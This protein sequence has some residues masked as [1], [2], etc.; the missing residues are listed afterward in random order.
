MTFGIGNGLIP[1]KAPIF[2]DDFLGKEAFSSRKPQSPTI[3]R[4][5]IQENQ[6]S[7]TED[8]EVPP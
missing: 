6:M 2:I 1:K 4:R 5:K 3:S 8:D 7:G